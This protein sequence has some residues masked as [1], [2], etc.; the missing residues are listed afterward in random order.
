[1]ANFAAAIRNRGAVGRPHHP[2]TEA[3]FMPSA[4][5]SGDD[6]IGDSE[7]RPGGADA[8]KL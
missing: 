2:R 8:V 5:A 1:M 7:D 3:A 6:C 4:L